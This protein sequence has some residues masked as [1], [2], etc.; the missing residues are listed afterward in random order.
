MRSR[1]RPSWL[2]PEASVWHRLWS[3]RLALLAAFF[4]AM[5]EVLPAWQAAL[6][7]I[8]FA[9]LSTLCAIGSSMARLVRQ[10]VAEEARKADAEGQSC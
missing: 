3:V 8:P 10:P 9:V 2:I 6:S 5:A 7:P 4:G 1:R